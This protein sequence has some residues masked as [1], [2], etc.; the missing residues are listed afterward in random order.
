M[1]IQF[2]NIEPRFARALWLMFVAWCF[3]GAW[4]LELRAST[5]RVTVLPQFGSTPLVFDSIANVTAA[6]QKISVTRLDFLLSN[7]AFRR[8]D[9]AWLSLT[10]WAEFIGAR[11]GRTSFDL[12]DL[13][14][15]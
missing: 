2:S 8:S 7:F 6:G 1:K 3:A 5:L 12:C 11:D 9:G 13:P 10:N 4:S 15:A 14:A